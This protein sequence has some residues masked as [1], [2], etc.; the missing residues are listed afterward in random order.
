MAES[1]R[2]ESDDLVR[3]V[4]FDLT[5]WQGAA[6]DAYRAWADQ[7]DCSLQALAKASDTMALITEGAGLLIA[8]VRMTVRDA[9]ATVVSSLIVYAGE[10]IASLG[11]ATPVVVEQGV[12]VVRLVGR[13]DLPLAQGP[14]LQLAK[15]RLDDAQARRDRPGSDCAAA[16]VARA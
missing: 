8:T 16:R 3:A 10:L 12:H 2:A 9:V 6:S 1:V 14:D 13:E 5:E 11:T 7:R 15:P 4:R